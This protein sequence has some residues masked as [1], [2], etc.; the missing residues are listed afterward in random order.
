MCGKVLGAFGVSF[1][2]EVPV[3]CRVSA[4]DPR[5]MLL[6]LFPARI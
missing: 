1:V 3:L 6:L 4:A 2:C 5:V